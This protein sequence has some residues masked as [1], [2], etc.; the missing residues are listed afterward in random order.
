MSMDYVR[1]V[2]MKGIKPYNA[3][4]WT[5]PRYMQQIRSHLRAAFR[6]WK[7][8]VIAKHAARR[9]NQSDNKRLKW[10]SQCNHCK[11]WFKEKE[12]QVDHIEA[13][14]SLKELA[15]I[16]LFIQKLTVEEGYQVLCKECHKKVTAEERASPVTESYWMERIKYYE[17]QIE[18]CERELREFNNRK[19]K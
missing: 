5:K 6:Y 17:Q 2:M 14:G 15:D 13:C 8:I 4:T 16:P 10:E 12:T 3:G 18:R 11:K 1:S 19:P 9:P 7:P